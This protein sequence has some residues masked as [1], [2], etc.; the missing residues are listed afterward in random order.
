MTKLNIPCG[1]CKGE[2]DSDGD[3]GFLTMPVDGRI[4]TQPCHLDHPGVRDE[5]NR[6]ME[7]A[8]KAMTLRQPLHKCLALSDALHAQDKAREAEARPSV[9]RLELALIA[10]EQGRARLAADAI[11]QDILKDHRI[12]GALNALLL[13]ADAPSGP[14][15]P[16]YLSLARDLLLA[17]RQ[18]CTVHELRSEGAI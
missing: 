4:K 3:I 18:D 7:E 12:H 15:A 13:A 1:I 11:K 17:V 2:I 14:S 16:G 6:Q 9:M 8:T 5:Y 10:I